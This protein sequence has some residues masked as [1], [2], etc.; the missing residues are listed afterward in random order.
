MKCPYCAYIDS[1]VIDSRPSPDG[2]SI[3]RR[4][5]C[6]SCQKRFTTFEMTEKQRELVKNIGSDK[7]VMFNY[8]TGVISEDGVSLDNTQA[9]TGIALEETGKT[10]YDFPTLRVKETSDMDVLIRDEAG[11]ARVAVLTVNGRRTVANTKP[12]LTPEELRAITDLAGCHA[13]APAGN[14]VYGDER[15]IG[16]FPDKGAPCARVSMR[17]CGE[18]TDLV[19]GKAY[20]GKDL[21]AQIPAAYATFFMKK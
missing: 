9:L 17:D 12:F 8:A 3:R 14:T 19:T 11:N 21:D 7:M 16:V 18:Y 13:Y 6:L 4:R 5:E 10:E 2:S 1:K 20:V 15:F